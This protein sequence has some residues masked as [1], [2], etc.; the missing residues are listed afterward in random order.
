MAQDRAAAGVAV[1]HVEDRVV[2]RLLQ[3]LDEVEIEGAEIDDDLID[4]W[5][6]R[7]PVYTLLSLAQ[8]IQLSIRTPAEA[9]GDD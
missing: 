8:D 1:L 5:A 7:A 2:A 9:A 3:H 6:R 4:E